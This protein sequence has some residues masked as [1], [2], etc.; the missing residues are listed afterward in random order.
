VSLLPLKKRASVHRIR[1]A[2][3][4]QKKKKDHFDKKDLST[5]DRKLPI[6]NCPE[7]LSLL[8]YLILCFFYLMQAVREGAVFFLHKAKIQIRCKDQEN[9]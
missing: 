6:R 8:S 5:N 3:D 4:S 1:Y 7:G 2:L 9:L